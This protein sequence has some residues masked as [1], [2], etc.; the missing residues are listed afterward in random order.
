MFL[1]WGYD[2]RA[3]EEMLYFDPKQNCYLNRRGGFKIAKQLVMNDRFAI[4]RDLDALGHKVRR[5][6]LFDF[7]DDAKADELTDRREEDFD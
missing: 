6:F 4:Y 1:V 7:F 3:L 2:R 5:E